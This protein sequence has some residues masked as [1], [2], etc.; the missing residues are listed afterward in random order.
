MSHSIVLLSGGLDSAVTLAIALGEGRATALTFDYGQRHDREIMS[1]RSIAD[2]YGIDH[3]VIPLDLSAF[4]SALIRGDI[5]VPDGLE[6]REGIPPTYV[7][8][9]NI[10]FL[11]M[12]LGLAESWG[13]D[14]IHI[15][16]NAVDYSGYP[17]CRP[18]FIEAFQRVADTGTRGGVEGRGVRIVAPI[19]GLSKAE[20]VRR[21]HELGVPFE[22]TWSC[23]RGGERP[24]GW[25]DSCLIR[26]RGFREAGLVDPLEHEGTRRP[27]D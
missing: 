23:Y 20:I 12:A 24:C 16:A 5:E 8:A 1:S 3:V 2:R 6:G 18:E 22:L 21:G 19:I 7:P 10:I 25:C 15:G 13:A 11:A 26:R 4:R 14:R 17:D 9:R 27:D